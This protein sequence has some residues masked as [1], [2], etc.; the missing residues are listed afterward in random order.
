MGEDLFDGSE[1]ISDA[2]E[3]LTVEHICAGLPPGVGWR[4]VPNPPQVLQA[5]STA[6]TLRRRVRRADGPAT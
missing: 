2:A 6:G 3:R 1:G 5:C 4:C